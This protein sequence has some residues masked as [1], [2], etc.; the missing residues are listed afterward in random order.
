VTFVVQIIL[1][2]SYKNNKSINIMIKTVQ[3]YALIIL[4]VFKVLCPR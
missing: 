2:S 3:T 1:L 4:F